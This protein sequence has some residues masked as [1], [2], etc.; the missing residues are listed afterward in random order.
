MSDE[1]PIPISD[2]KEGE[3]FRFQ[4]APARVCRLDQ[5]D[6]P[7]KWPSDPSRYWRYTDQFGF[8][9]GVPGE[10][11]VIRCEPVEFVDHYP[12]IKAMPPKK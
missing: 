7:S 11:L 8:W 5:I 3:Y 6:Q 1:A 9:D 12:H 4:Q 10:S 2:L